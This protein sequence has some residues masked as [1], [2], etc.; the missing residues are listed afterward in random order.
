MDDLPDKEKRFN[1]KQYQNAKKSRRMLVRF[2]IYSIVIGFLIY[3]ILDSSSSDQ[4]KNNE[5]GIDYFDIE[6]NE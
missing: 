1:F 5:E 2:I 4:N 6:T 3:L